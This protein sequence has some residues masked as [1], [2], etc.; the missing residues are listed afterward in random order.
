M[1]RILLFMLLLSFVAGCHKLHDEVS[2][3]GKLLKEKRDIASFNSIA[4]EGAF[5]IQVVSQKPLSL[6]IQGDDNILPLITTEVSNNVLHIR[7]LRGY[8]ATE[9]ITLK[10]SVP[11]LGGISSSGAGTFEISGIKNEKFEINAN[12]AP[13]IKVS[14]ETNL[15]NI[16]TN[17]AAKIDTHKLRAAR[18][19][20]E[21]K[22]VA[23]VDVYAKDQLDVSVSGPSHVTYEGDPVV[24]Q[25]VYG[26]G[27]VT[28]KESS[29]S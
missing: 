1:K 13:T 5:N 6:E 20:V 11:D 12:G 9:P 29:G 28:K 16:D 19:V 8:S 18:A 22:G 10:I 21:S 14:G 27:S 3:S 4:T 17:G 23:K 24:K 15:V 25:N 7:N 26:P 2:G